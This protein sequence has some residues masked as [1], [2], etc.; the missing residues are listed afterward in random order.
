METLRDSALFRII[1]AM[2]AL[3]ARTC[4]T[5]KT[6][7]FETEFSPYQLGG[8]SGRCL[9]NDCAAEEQAHIISSLGG[10]DN[11]VEP[12]FEEDPETCLLHCTAHKKEICD[13]CKSDYTVHTMLPAP[14]PPAGPSW[15]GTLP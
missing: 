10:G 14:L 7:K 6:E 4:T 9:C 2:A 5:C 11:D 15:P 3:L 12:R 1:G 13:A 8:G